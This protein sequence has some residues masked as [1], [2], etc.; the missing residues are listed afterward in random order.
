MS[1]P[2]QVY[3][4]ANRYMDMVTSVLNDATIGILREE[5]RHEV[6]SGFWVGTSRANV[7][8]NYGHA[9]T[10]LLT[11]KIDPEDIEDEALLEDGDEYLVTK[12][13]L[14]AWENVPGPA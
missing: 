14:V 1:Y 5:A 9:G 10:V 4:V 12:A 6:P 13:T 8:E 2:T 3:K 7:L 11:Y